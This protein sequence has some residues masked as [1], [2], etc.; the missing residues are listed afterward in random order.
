MS[1]NEN[2]VLEDID[3]FYNQHIVEKSPP[4]SSLDEGS[5]T[6]ESRK[7]EIFFLNQYQ[8]YSAMS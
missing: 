6:I 5:Y 2:D 3:R 4:S 7:L 1:S 8:K